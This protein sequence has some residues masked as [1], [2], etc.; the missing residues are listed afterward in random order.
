MAA[1]AGGTSLDQAPGDDRLAGRRVRGFEGYAN[2]EL[3]IGGLELGLV[4]VHA[5][6]HAGE[7]GNGTTRGCAA[8]GD[9]KS[10][11]ERFTGNGELQK[12]LPISD[13]G[14]WGVLRS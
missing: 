7:G 8:H 12:M 4:V 13:R 5:E 14:D 3:H 10:S 11:E 6:Q 9:A 2:A 1:C